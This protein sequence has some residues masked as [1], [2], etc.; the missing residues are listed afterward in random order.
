[1]PTIYTYSYIHYIR[2][3]LHNVVAYSGSDT[4]MDIPRDALI[5]SHTQY[6][7]D[8]HGLE[9][10]LMNVRICLGTPGWP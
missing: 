10:A 7:C 8:L 1:M 6:Q 9:T 4:L 2:N 5:L 3:F